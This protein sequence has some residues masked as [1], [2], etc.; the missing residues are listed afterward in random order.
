MKIK[1]IKVG[2]L[3]ENCYLLNNNS[4]VLIIDPGDEVNKIEKAIDGKVIGVL[5]TH[6]HFD[7]I[8]ALKEIC[9]R[10]N[11]IPNEVNDIDFNFITIQTPGHSDDSKTYYF[12]DYNMMFC[13]DF[14]FENSIGRCDLPTGNI[15]DMKNSLKLIS[16]YPDEI[17][18]Y[19]GHGPSTLLGKEKGNFSS[20]FM[21]I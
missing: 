15:S 18:I 9:S 11:V 4:K 12:K 21:N 13:G 2:Y 8:G 20:Y 6:N 10:Y 3:Q 1:C 17:M 5:I 19:P 7:H 16:K 14:I